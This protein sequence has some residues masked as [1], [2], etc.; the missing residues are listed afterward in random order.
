MTSADQRR[1]CPYCGSDV[2]LRNCV[3]VSTNQEMNGLGI[4]AS[5][6]FGNGSFD[7]DIR[8]LG[9]DRFDETSEIEAGPQPSAGRVEL[10]GRYPILANIPEPRPQPQTFKKIANFWSDSTDELEPV[11]GRADPR[12]L[13][14]R[15]C[16]SCLLPLPEQIDDFDVHVVAV[17][18]LNGAG[19]SHFLA[20]ALTEALRGGGLDDFGIDEFSAVGDTAAHIHRDYFVRVYREQRLFDPTPPNDRVVE[21]P[22]IFRVEVD[23][24]QPFLLLT[25]DLSGEALTDHAKRAAHVSFI[26]RAAAVIFLAD[27]WDMDMVLEKLPIPEHPANR[28]MSQ[29]DLLEA[30]LTEMELDGREVRPHLCLTISKADLLARVLP[31]PMKFL[32]PPTAKSDWVKNVRDVSDE[33]RNALLQLGENRLVK[34]ADRYEEVTYLAM[35]P[36]GSETAGRK[37]SPLRCLEP[38]AVAIHMAAAAVSVANAR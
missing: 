12:H 32:S 20:A 17:V 33:V 25:Y 23:G 1:R 28:N 3:I 19:K 5:I 34:I 38:L 30:V 22:L 9:E 13:P 14:R 10:S 36:L 4:G 7:A 8:A 15:Q 29:T 21:E 6:A 26:R 18:G 35:A 31:G 16:P 37:P 24:R 2:L 11:A 27:P